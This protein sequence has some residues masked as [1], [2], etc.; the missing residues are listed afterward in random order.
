MGSD[1]TW[2]GAG[3]SARSRKARAGRPT[4]RGW[5][6]AHRAAVAAGRLATRITGSGSPTR[7]EAPTGCSWPGKISTASHGRRMIRIA[8]NQR[9][10]R[11]GIYV[12]DGMYVIG[13]DGEHPRRSLRS[14][15]TGRVRSGPRRGRRM[16]RSSPT[17]GPTV[18]C[19]SSL[20]PGAS[21]DRS[22]MAPHRHGRPTVK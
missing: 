19:P 17:G 21:L 13:F 1:P 10:Y 15:R 14:S 11:D 20:S 4:D 8:F 16:G 22:V 12:R 9:Y 3:A 6:S 5:R 18:G 7:R 2:S